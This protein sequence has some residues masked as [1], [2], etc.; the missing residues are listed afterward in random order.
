MGLVETTIEVTKLAG[1]LANPELLQEATKANT[2]ALAMSRENLDLHKKVM[3]LEAQIQQLQAR[4]EVTARVFRNGGF[5]FLE[6]DPAP[7]C[8]KCWDADRKL[9]HLREV[10]ARRCPVCDTPNIQDL[11]VNPRREDAGS[12]PAW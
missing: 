9:I 6:G 3:H 2:E 12:V 1:K 5:M 11:P 10:G 4:A 7:H 8:S